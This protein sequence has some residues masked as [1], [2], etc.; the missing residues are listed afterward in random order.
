MA[1]FFDQ[2]DAAEQTAP[3]SGNFFDQF[4]IGEKKSQYAQANESAGAL[5][6]LATGLEGGA[7]KRALGIVQT[8]LEAAG[9]SDTGLYKD[10]LDLAK[11]YRQETEGTGAVGFIGGVLGDPLTYAPVPGAAGAT[12]LGGLAKLGA[13]YGGAASGLGEKVEGENRLADTGVGVGLGVATS[14][15]A[16]GVSKAVTS[17]PVLDVMADESGA[18]GRNVRGAGLSKA[19]STVY[20]TLVDDLGMSQQDAIQAIQNAGRGDIPLSLPEQLDSTRLLGMEKRLRQATGAAGDIEK[21][22]T[23]GRRGVISQKIPQ[24]IESIGNVRTLDEAGAR[25]SEAAKKVFSVMSGKRSQAVKP[26]YDQAY[27]MPASADA[28]KAVLDDP[29]TSSVFTKMGKDPRVASRLKDYPANSVGWINEARK[30]LS[31]MAEEAIRKGNNVAARDYTMAADRLRNVI[32]SSGSLI[33]EANKQFSKLSKPIN[34]AEGSVLKLLADMESGN[35]QDASQK[36]FSSTPAQIKYARR[37]IGAVDRQAWDDLVASH[38]S[39]IGDKVNHSPVKFL[40]AIGDKLPTG[41]KYTADK[42]RAALSEK[43]AKALDVLSDSLER[44]SRIRMGSDTMMNAEAGAMLQSEL[45]GGADLA[46]DALRDGVSIKRMAV[47]AAMWIRN[48]VMEKRYEE[49]A[50]IFTGQG[51]DDFVN[52]LSR[53]KPSSPEAYRAIIQKIQEIE[54]QAVISTQPAIQGGNQ[55]LRG[56]QAIESQPIPANDAM[57]ESQTLPPEAMVKPSLMDRIA[58]A[59]SGGNPNAVN[60]MSSASG[61]FQF[62][63]DTWKRMVDKHGKRLGITVADKNKP[64]A[65]RKM[66]ELLA[67]ENAKVIRAVAKR[68]PTEGEIYAA[69]FFGAPDTAKMLRANESTPAARVTPKAAKANPSIF[70][71]GKRPRTVAEVMGILE[72]KVS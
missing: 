61:L 21:A 39:F 52:K 25:A 44:A 15:V 42:F 45:G 16:Y 60:P 29:L 14:P 32:D 31:G 46:V 38:L 20:R 9:Q 17:K 59:E 33:S 23:E 19:Q 34:K 57:P 2:F 48:K 4:D 62:T 56:S 13:V 54:K 37:M 7:K 71:D 67:D 35:V 41:N 66:A 27:K 49:L 12:T 53:M 28:L 64:E 63:N 72:S 18:V 22:F 24:A 69:H 11:K 55:L 5:S 26:L 3:A 36:L 58:M 47:D 10:T 68:E 40:N 1:N 65:Q 51:S 50:K 43:Q 6:N 70:F 8:L 30:E